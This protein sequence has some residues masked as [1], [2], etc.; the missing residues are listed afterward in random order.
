MGY[1]LSWLAVRGKPVQE[2]RDALGF[3]PTGQ[4][5][6]IPESD[7]S[8]A[9]M[10]NGWYLIVA[11]H[12]EQVASDSALHR[13]SASGCEI[14]T[15]FI[16]EH[17]MVSKSTGWKDGTMRWSVTHDSEERLWHL[18]TQGEPPEGFVA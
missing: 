10:P 11:N 16:E 8:A 9:E 12:S 4:R 14:V 6:E 7:F 5:E 15:C 2:V 13:L 3:R 1:S 17:V 18:D